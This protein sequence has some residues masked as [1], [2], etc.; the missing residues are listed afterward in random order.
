MAR[1]P[2]RP[3]RPVDIGVSPARVAP[4]PPPR[5]ATRVAPARTI[6]DVRA[7]LARLR[8]AT[9]ERQV[10]AI[11]ERHSD[12]APTDFMEP[13]TGTPPSPAVVHDDFAATE[14]RPFLGTLE[15]PPRTGR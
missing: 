2:S 5:L 6:E 15:F 8:E 14:Y 7:D 11:L 13:Q 9:R 3:A 4:N 12:F 10:Q 1:L